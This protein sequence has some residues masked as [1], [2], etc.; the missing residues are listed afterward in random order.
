MAYTMANERANLDRMVREAQEL[1][2]SIIAQRD[3]IADAVK[4]GAN[5]DKDRERLNKMIEHA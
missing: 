3:R 2:E 1:A 5:P 4:R